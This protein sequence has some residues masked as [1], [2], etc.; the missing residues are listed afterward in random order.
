MLD[1]DFRRFTQIVLGAFKNLLNLLN[2]LTHFR[3]R[4]HEL[5]SPPNVKTYQKILLILII[6]C[7]CIGCDQATKLIAK[8]YLGGTPPIHLLGGTVVLHYAE[9]QGSFLGL[10]ARLPP[11]VRFWIFVVLAGLMIVG[12]LGVVLG[13]PNLNAGVV[14]GAALIIGGGIGNLI[15]RLTH[16]GT[17]VD[18]LNIGIGKVRTGIFNMADV[19]I[20]VGIGLLML[21]FAKQKARP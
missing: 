10:G 11:T 12:V 4:Q 6:V 16:Q 5:R 9:N 8:Q 18:F 1:A 20:M 2:L 14:T 7:A 21:T 3:N 13:A 15:D 19:G 17:V